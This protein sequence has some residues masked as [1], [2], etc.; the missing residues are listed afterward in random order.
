MAVSIQM[1]YPLA[2]N[3]DERIRALDSFGQIDTS[4][5][6]DF[7]QIV[8]MASRIFDVP[9]ALI[10]LVHRDRQFFKARVGLD[11][12]ETG[13]NVSFCTYAIMAADVFVVPDASLDPRFSD[14]ALVTGYPCIRFYAGAPLLTKE[15]HGI[16]SLCL[17]DNKPRLDFSNRT[18]GCF[19]IWLPWCSIG[20]SSAV[21][22]VPTGKAAAASAILP[23]PRRT[24]LSALIATIALRRGTAQLRA[25]F[26]YSVEEALGRSLD[27]IVPKAMHARHGAGLARVAAGGP[28]RIIGTSVNLTA[29]RRD[30]SEFPIELSSPSGPRAASA[31]SARSSATSRC[32]PRQNAR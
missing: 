12:C 23:R 16:G 22:S 14:N 19:R 30:G 13:R 6:S 4:P 9:V 1:N 3:E 25:M 29:C 28:A 31:S 27:I 8:Q 17:I 18:G 7:D 15:G 32:G 21:W 20:W 26:G 5:D 10:S 2:D 24:A 11:V